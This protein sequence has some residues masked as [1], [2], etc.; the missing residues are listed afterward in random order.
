ME[1]YE[2]KGK[3]GYI[4]PA[5]EIEGKD[6]SK[7][8]GIHFQVFP[9]DDYSAFIKDVFFKCYKGTASIVKNLREG[10]HVQVKF[11]PESRR[12]GDK[13]FNDHKAFWVTR[14]Q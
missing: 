9:D 1:G 7:Y 10:D 6:G 12:N 4:F 14:I 13:I 3:V 11:I 8:E 2:M 5:F